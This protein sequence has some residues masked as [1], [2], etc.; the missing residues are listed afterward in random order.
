MC[1]LNEETWINI[2]R[3]RKEVKEGKMEFGVIDKLL[4]TLWMLLYVIAAYNVALWMRL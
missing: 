3:A 2:T 1:E 4:A